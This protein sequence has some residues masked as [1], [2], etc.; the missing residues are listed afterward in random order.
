[1][2]LTF[3]SGDEILNHI[4]SYVSMEKKKFQSFV[5]AKKNLIF[6]GENIFNKLI[7]KKATERNYFNIYRI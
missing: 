2:I 7:V 6:G 5:S 3:E 1:M 4:I